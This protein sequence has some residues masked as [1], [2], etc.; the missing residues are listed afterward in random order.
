VYALRTINRYPK[1]KKKKKKNTIFHKEVADG[2][3]SVYMDDIAIHTKPEHGETE[4]KHLARHRSYVHIV[5]E[6]LAENNLYLKPAKCSFEQAQ[7]VYLGV[8]VGNG[9]LEM[10]PKKLSSVMEWKIP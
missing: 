4:A 9:R 3:L 10:D 1:K 7:I 6:R 2:W 8:V 5:L